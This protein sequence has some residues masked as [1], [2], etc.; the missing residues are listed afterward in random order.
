MLRVHP[1]VMGTGL[2][3]EKSIQL[4]TSSKCLAPIC[5]TGAVNSLLLPGGNLYHSFNSVQFTSHEILLKPNVSTVGCCLLQW[6]E[7]QC[8]GVGVINH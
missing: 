5:A 7:I 3:Q 1:A 4:Q 8:V 2:W 6:L